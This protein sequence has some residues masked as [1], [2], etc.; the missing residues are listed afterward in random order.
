MNMQKYLLLLILLPVNLFAQQ[1]NVKKYTTELAGTVVLRDVEDKYNAMVVNLEAPV[2]D[3]NTDKMRLLK[4]KEQSAEL[5]PHKQSNVR[6]RTNATVPVPTVEAS[7]LVDSFSGIPPD[8]DMAISKG[9]TAV[10]VINSRISVVDG[11][12]GKISYLK[13][14]GF[15]SSAV[16]LNDFTNDNKYDPKV[17][18]DPEADRFITVMLNGRDQY[19]YIIVGFS[20]SNDPAGAWAFYKFYGDYKPDST[21]FDYP[22]VVMTKDELFVTGNKIGYSAP[23]ETGFTE[24]VIYQINKKDGYNAA[25]T[26]N[27]QLWDGIRY[28]GRS[29]RNLFPV[30][31]G[32]GL[33]GPEQYFLSNRNFDVQND[34]IFLVK[35]PNIQGS[36]NNNITIKHLKAP[37]KYGVPPNG[38]QPDTSVVLNTNDGRILGAYQ[39]NEEIQFVS[40]SVDPTNG[41]AGIYHTIISDYKNNPEI[42][43]AHIYSTSDLDFGYPNILYVGDSL[44]HNYSMISFEYTGPN[45]LPGLGVIFNANKEYS[46]LVK[47]KE[48]E[49]SVKWLTGKNQRW[50]D[51]TGA[52]VDF[53]DTSSI[54]ISGLFG[55]KNN[56]YGSWMAKIKSPYKTVYPDVIDST[57]TNYDTTVTKFYPNPV[58]T[59][60]NYEFHMPVDGVVK[61]RIY[62]MDGSVTDDLIYQNVKKGRNNIQFNTGHLSRGIYFLKGIRDSGEIVVDEKFQKL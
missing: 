58:L 44:G 49:G 52:Q 28:D 10:S 9:N 21:W 56:R 46:D 19:N 15:F 55:Q 50:G 17:Q 42:T 38:R 40:T 60:V 5:F 61:F 11:T 23:W 43:H 29:I 13:T 47:I 2:P 27:Y 25:A 31:P 20:Q 34:S 7:F 8:N 6:Y 35:I 48:G 32:R 26:L 54:W 4:V 3:G 62:S 59:F 41:S 12:T 51:Y 22:G 1:A 14:L 57:E 45:T 36:S 33:E 53:K 18:Y 16:G 39:M 37:V 30:R 24:S